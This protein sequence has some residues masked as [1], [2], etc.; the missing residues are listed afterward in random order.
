MLKRIKYV[1]IAL[2]TVA[3]SMTACGSDDK[4][5]RVY[6][7]S[8]SPAEISDVVPEGAVCQLTVQSTVD[9]ICKVDGVAEW[10]EIA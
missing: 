3:V 2:M 7:L 6:E 9:W 4:D 8:V 10:I 1:M 5:E